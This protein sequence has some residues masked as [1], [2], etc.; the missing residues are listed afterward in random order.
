MSVELGLYIIDKRGLEWFTLQDI[1]KSTKMSNKG[2][3]KTKIC[4][5]MKGPEWHRTHVKVLSMVKAG[6]ITGQYMVAPGYKSKYMANIHNSKPMKNKTK[7][8]GRHSF[9]AKRIS[10]NLERSCRGS[11][12]A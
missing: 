6:K 10:N 12:G 4:T 11:D 9:H 5:V 8:N 7:T 3:N 1:L 2:P